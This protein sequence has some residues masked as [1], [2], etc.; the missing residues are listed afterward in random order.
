MESDSRVDEDVSARY[1]LKS[2]PKM[3]ELGWYRD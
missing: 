1:A 3:R 2:P